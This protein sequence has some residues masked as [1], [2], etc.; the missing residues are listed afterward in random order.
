MPGSVEAGFTQEDG[1]T[2]FQPSGG[3]PDLLTVGF[4]LNSIAEPITG[5]PEAKVPSANLR[6]IQVGFPPGFAGYPT[7]VGE[8]RPDQLT[9]E[10]CPVSSEVGV[11][12]ATTL[13]VSVLN[14]TTFTQ[15]VAP[16]Y[17]MVHPKGVVSDLAFQIANNPI[18][19]RVSL[20]PAHGYALKST[21]SGA[22]ET[23]PVFFQKMTLWG[24]PADPSHDSERCPGFHGNTSSECSAGVPPKPFLS[25][26]SQCGVEQ[27]LKISNYDSW[28]ERG[29]FGPEID[30]PLG[31]STECEKPAFEP[32]AEV[33]GTARRANS[34]TGLNVDLHVPQD[35]EANDQATPPVK[36]VRLT[37]PEGMTV[38]PGFAAGLEGCSEAQIGLGNSEPVGCPAAS[39]IGSVSLRTPMLSEPV[40]GSLYMAQQGANPFGAPL[41]VYM[42]L[43]DTEERG[44]LVKVPGRLDLNGSTGQITASFEDLPQLPFEDVSIQLRS[45]EG[46][47]L[48]SAPT[49]GPQPVRMQLTSWA[50]PDRT[51]T[52]EHNLEVTEGASGSACPSSAGSGSFAPAMTAGTVAPTA[53]AFSPF[54]LRVSRQDQDQEISRLETALPPGLTA[55]I[56]GIPYCPEAV[57]AGISA[58]EGTGR[59]QL[60]DPSCPAQSRVGTV[61]V[62]VGSGSS[63]A[64]F[65]GQVYLAGP[66]A[67][68][69]LSLAIV[70]PAVVGPFDFG[71]VVVRAGIQIDP[72]TAQVK[73]VSD[74]LPSIVHGVLVRTRDIRFR[75]DRPETTLNPTSCD[76][77][78]VNA[79]VFAP[80]GVA[81]SLATPFQVGGCRHLRFRP[82][83]ALRLK[84]SMRRAQY[85]ALH[86]VLRTRPGE[87]NIAR[88]VVSLPHAEFLAEEHIET[89]CTRV[90]FAEHACPPGSIYGYAKATTPLL[91]KPLRGPVYL[92][93]SSHGIPDLVADLRG[94]FEITLVGRI[95]SHNQGI[96]TTFSV[97]PDA[98][99]SRFVLDMRG[100]KRGL[101]R[102][103]SNLCAH[104]TRALVKM[105]GHNGKGSLTRPRLL[106]RCGRSRGGH[107]P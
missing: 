11:V 84:G 39:R 93:S 64:F 26:P 102:N 31:E 48:V 15:Q 35:M 3:H 88:T 86:A 43:H 73:V 18:H 25:L 52:I 49:C 70:V 33:A 67:G 17:N 40:E 46:A 78:A 12:S 68:A 22:N 36:S 92:R 8:C 61:N 97:V 91:D 44:V 57:I 10:N 100:G 96:R 76:R 103:S 4:D 69:P 101:L 90:Q 74:P 66:Y 75:M 60:A 28:Q 42:S 32:S 99:V 20:D 65:P 2:P 62:G 19:V 105:V 53:G 58:A 83:L 87:A 1:L 34:P 45:G 7:S 95:D 24:I 63:P 106:G 47:P 104:P 13:P 89:V 30:Y 14:D 59:A 16:I 6:D 71:N 72:V 98:P 5:S 82:R 23:L 51:V 41:A 94:Q 21:V 55:K 79:D 38:S 50:Q 9:S 77:M 27:T 85:P 107:H 54:L 81:A 80:G 29:V 37:L 56:A